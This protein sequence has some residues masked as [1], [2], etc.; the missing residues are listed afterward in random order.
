MPD[1]ITGV[2]QLVRALAPD[3]EYRWSDS[4]IAQITYLADMIITEGADVV[5]A[6]HDITLANN[7]STYDLPADV[8]AIHNVQYAY[9]GVRFKEVIEPVV[10][11]DLDWMDL[12]WQ[13]STGTPDRYWLLGAPGVEDVSKIVFWRII[14]TVSG[15]KVRVNYLKART[16]MAE[17]EAVDAPQEVLQRVYLPCVLGLLRAGEAAEEAES[18]M[19]EF[20]GEMHRVRGLYQHRGGELT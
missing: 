17:V 5:W 1:L 16:T 14:P 3:Y 4:L 10:P 18:L 13:E 6:T 20:R 7:V 19:M 11:D 9:D 15:E 2:T 12:R 8:I